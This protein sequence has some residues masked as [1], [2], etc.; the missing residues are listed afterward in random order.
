MQFEPGG[1]WI[2]NIQSHYVWNNKNLSKRTSSVYLMIRLNGH[3]DHLTI[4]TVSLES[5]DWLFACT[6]TSIQGQS[7]V[8]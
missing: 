3:S 8:W 1:E 2:E 7:R 6:A 5:K 4:D